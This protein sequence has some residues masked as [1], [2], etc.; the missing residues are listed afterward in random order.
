[1]SKLARPLSLVVVLVLVLTLSVLV[2]AQGPTVQIA[3][4]ATHG[5]ILTDAAGMTLYHFTRDAVNQPSQCTGDCATI[6]PPLTIASGAPVAP[7]GLT[8]A[9]STVARA[10]GSLQVT[11][12][13]LPLYLYANDAA[14]GET[15]GQGVNNVWFV[16]LAQTA[17]ATGTTE[18]TTAATTEA[19]A[20]ATTAATEAATTATTA[21]TEAATAAP[22]TA[23]TVVAQAATATTG[24][25]A[26]TAAATATPA[27]TLPTTGAETSSWTLTI[28]LLGGLALLAGAG[29]SVA[30]QRNR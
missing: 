8:G 23:A 16:A 29:L 30:L 5:M 12:N 28:V 10:D 1:M 18:A 7:E 9:L 4:N 27:Q 13:G 11:Y 25:A 14:A 2:F 24:A 15:N 6:W 3:N 22:T 26:A 21:A 17:A 19:T 20:A